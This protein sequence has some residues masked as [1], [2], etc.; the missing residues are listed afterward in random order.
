MFAEPGEVACREDRPIP[1]E[2]TFCDAALKADGNEWP[3]AFPWNVLGCVRIARAH[4]ITE[5]VDQDT[6]LDLKKIIHLRAGWLDG[7]RIDI[8]YVPTGE[9]NKSP[10][11]EDE[12]GRYEMVVWKPSIVSRP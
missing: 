4:P 12:F 10:K 11:Y 9:F 8:R 5:Q 3:H 1:A 7:V 6:G 2:A